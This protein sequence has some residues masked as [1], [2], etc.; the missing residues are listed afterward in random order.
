VCAQLV[1]IFLLLVCNAAS[2]VQKNHR[3]EKK[4]INF[5]LLKFKKVEKNEKKK[6]VFVTHY[7]ECSRWLSHDITH[8]F[9][10]T[11]VP[12][13]L[14]HNHSTSIICG[15]HRMTTQGRID[16]KSY[17][18]SWKLGIL[19]LLTFLSMTVKKRGRKIKEF[20]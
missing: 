6:R 17:I 19:M 5:F 2:W 8:I 1:T 16:L 18:F 3:N 9:R 10:T 11:S 12:L 14:H 13:F 7:S 15:T 4:Y 20:Q